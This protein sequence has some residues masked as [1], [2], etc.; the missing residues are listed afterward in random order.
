MESCSIRVFRVSAAT[1]R[2]IPPDAFRRECGTLRGSGLRRVRGLRQRAGA[3]I[4]RRVALDRESRTWK[5]EIAMEMLSSRALLRPHAFD[6]TFTFYA[7]RLGL[8]VYRERGADA[9]AA[10]R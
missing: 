1:P 9:P 7:E 4:W 6:R 10:P 3:T 2:R 5:G 8:H